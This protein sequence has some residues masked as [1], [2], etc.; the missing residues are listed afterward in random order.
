MTDPS[1]HNNSY[2]KDRLV[3]CCKHLKLANSYFN[4]NN[5]HYVPNNMNAKRSTENL[6]SNGANPY[7]SQSNDF[8]TPK[9]VYNNSHAEAVNNMKT[10][11]KANLDDQMLDGMNSTG[12]K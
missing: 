4:N 11:N 1:N 7:R 9:K 8:R 10:V 5:T 3:K 2:P 12:Y 6:H